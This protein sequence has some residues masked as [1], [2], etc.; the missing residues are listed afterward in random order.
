[1]MLTRLSS[2]QERKGTGYCAPFG[3]NAPSYPLRL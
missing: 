2:I 3:D 1:M